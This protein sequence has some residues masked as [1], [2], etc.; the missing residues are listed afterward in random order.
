MS[1][2]FI[3]GA[4][5]S[6]STVLGTAIPVTAVSN[7]TEAVATAAAPPTNG[8]ILLVKSGW[9]ALDDTVARAAGTTASSFKLEGV[10]TVDTTI[11]PAGQGAGSVQVASSFVPLDQIRD[12]QITGGDQQ[13]AQ[14]QY[15]ED[16]N[17]RQRQKPTFKN[18]MQIAITMDYDPKKPWY[19]AL[20]AADQ[21]GEPVVISCVLTNK[22]TM[23]YLAYPSFNKVPTAAMNENMQNTATFSLIAEPIRYEAV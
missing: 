21:K 2:I 16:R 20:I 17:S 3:N 18:A 12:I 6:M 9:S 10:N 7:A 8:A 14:W 15:A 22:A 19:A 23:L 1:S 5:Y 4:Q 13:F 11:F